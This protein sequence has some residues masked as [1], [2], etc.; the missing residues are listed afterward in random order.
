M[1]FQ[2]LPS[3]F[4]YIGGKFYCLLYQFTVFLYS[5]CSCSA[6]V[7]VTRNCLYTTGRNPGLSRR[8]PRN[9]LHPPSRRRRQGRL[10]QP[11][12]RGV[13]V[14]APLAAPGAVRIAVAL[15]IRQP[16]L[17]PFRPCQRVQ[18]DGAAVAGQPD[19]GG[20]GSGGDSAAAA[21]L[22]RPGAATV[23]ATAAPSLFRSHA[24][25]ERGSAAR[26]TTSSSRARAAAFQLR[27]YWDAGAG[28]PGG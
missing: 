7:R 27:Q 8:P 1:N 5:V 4:P 18:V 26:P 20:S 21:A 25:A 12:H 14:S 15:G 2:P 16:R 23:A 13:D 28:G 9:L 24:A 6:A 3:E 11:S 19:N 17:L 22:F 10:H